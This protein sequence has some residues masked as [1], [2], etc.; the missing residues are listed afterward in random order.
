[1][2]KSHPPYPPELHR[3]MVELIR[4]GRSR[5]ELGRKFDPSAHAIRNWVRQAAPIDLLRLSEAAAR[6]GR[7]GQ[8]SGGGS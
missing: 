7:Q 2:P 4:C 6:W 5:G 8:C 1:M 3:R